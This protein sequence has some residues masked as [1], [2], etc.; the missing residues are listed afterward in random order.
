MDGGTQKNCKLFPFIV[1]LIRD[2]LWPNGIFCGEELSAQHGDGK[3]ESG[4]GCAGSKMVKVCG[5]NIDNS[6]GIFLIFFHS[7]TRSEEFP[8]HKSLETR[9]FIMP[10]IWGRIWELRDGN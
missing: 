1:V 5:R 4:G 9:K 10:T 7:P 6:K 2:R 3:Y 8:S